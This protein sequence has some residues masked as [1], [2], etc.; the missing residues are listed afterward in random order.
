MRGDL[1]QLGMPIPGSVIKRHFFLCVGSPGSS[2]VKNPP[3][4]HE[5]SSVPGSGRSPGE[6]NGNSLQ[7]SCLEN[8][9]GQRSLAGC[10]PWDCKESDTTERLST[11][12][13]TILGR[14][15]GESGLYSIYKVGISLKESR[16]Q[17][18][19]ISNTYGEIPTG[20]EVRKKKSSEK[21]SLPHRHFHMI[22]GL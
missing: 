20:S 1:R 22:M 3:A 14:R 18:G 10:V 4:K 7:H 13:S 2:A 17:K 19:I 5:M 16:R 9:H 21:A 11:A 15:D 12:H 8:P 6:G